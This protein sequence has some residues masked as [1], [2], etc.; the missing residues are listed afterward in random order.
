MDSRLERAA[1][2]ELLARK[3]RCAQ[4]LVSDKS[5]IENPQVR[6]PDDSLFNFLT[7]VFSSLG[8]LSSRVLG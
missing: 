7:Y 5:E 8:E 3:A 1:L 6:Q 4:A 2:I